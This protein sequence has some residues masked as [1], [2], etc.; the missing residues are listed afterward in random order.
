MK[1]LIPAILCLFCLPIWATESASSNADLRLLFRYME[2]QA[3]FDAQHEQQLAFWEMQL[4]QCD[5]R[6]ELYDSLFMAARSYNFDRALHY[7]AFL[8]DE[9]VRSGNKNRIAHALVQKAFAYLS[10][11]L[12]HECYQLMAGM[13]TTGI[14]KAVRAEYSFTRARLLYDMG[15]YNHVDMAQTYIEQGNACLKDALTI[16]TFNDTAQY[17]SCRAMLDQHEGKYMYAIQEFQT[18]LTDSRISDHDRAIYYSTIAYL[19]YLLK[20]PTQYLHY[21][22]LAA[23]ADISS[24]TKETTAMR[25]VAECL[26]EQ[27]EVEY[28]SQCIRKAQEDASFY[29]ARHR[30]VEISQILP[31]IEQQNNDKQHQLNRR[32]WFL[33]ACLFVLMMILLVALI[34][35]IRRNKALHAARHTIEQMNQN[36]LVANRVKEVYLGNF[37]RQQSEFISNVE[38]YQQHVR[39]MAVER[40]YADLMSVPKQVEASQRKRQFYKQLDEMLLSVFPTF[41]EDFNALLRPG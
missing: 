24:S 31:I 37:L 2:Q 18:A 32:I 6:Y 10:A 41:V 15:D 22:I 26:F 11:G 16:Y 4:E 25:H 27:G 19:F 39:K 28:A 38:M 30:Q 23:I 13:D 33:A 36:L 21:N 5:N 35:I 8:H 17:W 20:D 12:F 14:D 34:F 9:A 29:N 1:K 7:V 40:R 3:E